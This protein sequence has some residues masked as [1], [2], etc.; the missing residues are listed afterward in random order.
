MC[1]EADIWE[2][3]RHITKHFWKILHQLVVSVA[4]FYFW[5]SSEV[6]NVKHNTCQKYGNVIID[7]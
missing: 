1:C 5:Y 7:N 2:D 3:S 6:G 4:K